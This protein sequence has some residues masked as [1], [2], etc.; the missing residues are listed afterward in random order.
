MLYVHGNDTGQY[1]ITDIVSSAL[2]TPFPTIYPVHNL[3]VPAAP[4][5]PV[6]IKEIISGSM[7]SF[8]VI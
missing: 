2:L 7:L 8:G 6:S 4:G 5:P 3:P 1:I